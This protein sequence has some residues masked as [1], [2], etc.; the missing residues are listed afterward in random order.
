MTKSSALE[1]FLDAIKYTVSF[2]ERD[3]PMM[4]SNNT[5]TNNS[6]IFCSTEVYAVPN[7]YGFRKIEPVT[8]KQSMNTESPLAWLDRRVNEMRV[9]F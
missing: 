4:M 2:Y 9:P 3:M 7:Q 5:S 6:I 8:L 1:D